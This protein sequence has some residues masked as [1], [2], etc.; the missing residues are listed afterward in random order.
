MISYVLI[1]MVSLSTGQVV[2]ASLQGPMSQSWCVQLIQQAGYSG[3]DRTTRKSSSCLTWPDAQ[4]LL[5]Q[6]ACA[7]SAQP[8]PGQKGQQFDCVAPPAAAEAPQPAPAEA[9]APAAASPPLPQP[10]P[11][12]EPAATPAATPAEAPAPAAAPPGA[13]AA[14]PA[15]SAQPDPDVA[16]T[17]VST[18]AQASADARARESLFPTAPGTYTGI[19]V[20]DR[21]VIV[22]PKTF[23][24]TDCPRSV[25]TS[26]EHGTPVYLR[27]VSVDQRQWLL[28]QARCATSFVNESGTRQYQCEDDPAR[29]LGDLS[30]R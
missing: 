11:N 5:T 10:A 12:P 23:A 18:T 13:P 24:Q 8:N 14:P 4:R 3:E 22:A 16:A 28:A 25:N 20:R 15:P 27:C 2:H 7:R 21:N 29:Y 9:A 26:A 30:R 17:P 19:L 1:M 6:N